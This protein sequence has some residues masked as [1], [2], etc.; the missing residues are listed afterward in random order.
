MEIELQAVGY[1]DKPVLR[2]LFELYQYDFSEYENSDVDEHGL[3]GYRYLDHYW[4]EPGRHA[5]FIR[6]DGKLA[7]FALVRELHEG[8]SSPTHSIAEFFV[9]RKYR[10]RGVGREAATRLFDQFPGRWRVAEEESNLPAQAFWHK[11]IETYTRGNYEEMR[12]NN[13]EWR[14]LLQVFRTEGGKGAFE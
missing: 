1:D 2:N 8:Y 3:Y 5:F 11:V 13:D 14:G 4:T 9:L 6:V 7:G 10:R 12:M